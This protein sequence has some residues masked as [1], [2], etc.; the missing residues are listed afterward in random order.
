MVLVKIAVLIIAFAM[1]I[2]SIYLIARRIKAK[3]TLPGNVPWIFYLIEKMF[4]EDDSCSKEV[5][6]NE[7]PK[8]GQWQNKNVRF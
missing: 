4:G 6:E 1:A 2:V 3:P 7:L 5:K 8:A